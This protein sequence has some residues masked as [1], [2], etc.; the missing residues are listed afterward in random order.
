MKRLIEPPDRFTQSDIE[1]AERT[2]RWLELHRENPKTAAAIMKQN[3][4]REWIV[5]SKN[6][7]CAWYAA[8]VLAPANGIRCIARAAKF[9]KFDRRYHATACAQ[10][11]SGKL[12]RTHIGASSWEDR[13]VSIVFAYRNSIKALLP[14]QPNTAEK[15]AYRSSQDEAINRVA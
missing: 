1:D 11:G 7:P 10:R 9:G 12:R 6:I 3:G 8:D 5:K 15:M 4:E 13:K 14:M 2:L